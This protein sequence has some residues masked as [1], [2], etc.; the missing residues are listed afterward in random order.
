MKL[1]SHQ[2]IILEYLIDKSFHVD[3]GG[4]Y[5]LAKDC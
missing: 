2:T 3:A 4:E 1:Y 5:I